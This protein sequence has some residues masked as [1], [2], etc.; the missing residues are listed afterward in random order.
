M[1]L[2]CKAR[3]ATLVGKS[4]LL[5][6]RSEEQLMLLKNLG[7]GS[8]PSCFEKSPLPKP[9]RQKPQLPF[10]L[11]LVSFSFFHY[12][13]LFTFARPFKL[14]RVPFQ[15]QSVLLALAGAEPKNLAGVSDKHNSRSFRDFRLA[16]RAF[17]H[18]FLPPRIGVASIS[19][20]VSIKISPTLTGPYTFLR[21]I[22]PA[23]GP[24][25]ILH[26]T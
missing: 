16:K 5:K 11:N 12:N 21:I 2:F 19:V 7:F 17:R 26:R 13:L 18:Y 15:L 20:W 23:S 9:A 22:F 14:R 4:S 24:S 8:S 3:G 10:C 25:K 1:C 6:K